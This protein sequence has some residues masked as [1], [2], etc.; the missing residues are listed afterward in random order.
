MALCAGYYCPLYNSL[1]D[2][3]DSLLL[4]TTAHPLHKE[5]LHLQGNTT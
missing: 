2:F 5:S 4:E 1:C 3:I